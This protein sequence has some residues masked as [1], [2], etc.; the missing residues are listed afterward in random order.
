VVLTTQQN[1]IARQTAA[2]GRSIPVYVWQMPV[3]PDYFLRIRFK[4]LVLF[5]LSATA[6][7]S[8]LRT[9]GR[10]RSC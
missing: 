1:W 9:P 8:L 6:T 5:G 2:I 10:A 4:R 3:V 7:T